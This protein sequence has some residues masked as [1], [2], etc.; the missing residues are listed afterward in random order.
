[1]SYKGRTA[2]Q[3]SA[4]RVEDADQARK[5]KPF[6]GNLAGD[7]FVSIARSHVVSLPEPVDCEWVNWREAAEW[8]MPMVASARVRERRA[9]LALFEGLVG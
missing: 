6:T 1:M 4:S 2:S 8:E 3:V 7:Q 5:R 9:E